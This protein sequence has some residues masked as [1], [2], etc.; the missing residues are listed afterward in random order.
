MRGAAIPKDVDSMLV[1]LRDRAD[2]DVPSTTAGPFGVTSVPDTDDDD[3]ADDCDI[4]LDDE[5]EEVKTPSS[6]TKKR[7]LITKQATVKKSSNIKV[8]S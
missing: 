5:E 4:G 1:N 7:K 3:A 6:S 2:M 8:A